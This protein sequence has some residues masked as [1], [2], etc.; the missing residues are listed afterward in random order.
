MDQGTP[1][2]NQEQYPD[3]RNRRRAQDQGRYY[4]NRQR[5]YIQRTRPINDEDYLEEELPVEEYDAY[6][7]WED[8]VNAGEADEETYPE[9]IPRRRRSS[10]YSSTPPRR[11]PGPREPARARPVARKRPR[12]RK[13]SLPSMLLGCGLGMLVAVGLAIAVVLYFV[14]PSLKN[15]G[16]P[17]N[18][19]NPLHQ[20]TKEESVTTPITSLGTVEVCTK[21]GNVALLVD[22]SSATT[23]ITSKKM[24][25]ATSQGDA[26]QK[27]AQ[28]KV[29]IQ[30]PATVTQPLTCTRLPNP[31]NQQGTTASGEALI[32]NVVFPTTGGL[33]QDTTASTDITIH[34]PPGILPQTPSLQIGVEAPVGNITV[35]GLSGVYS[36]HGNTGAIK[37]TQAIL[38]SGSRLETGQKGVTFNGLLLIPPT[39]TATAPARYYI[40]SEQGNV[41][42]TLPA[43]LNIQVN[44]TTNIGKIKSDFPIQ[45]QKDPKDENSMSYNGPLNPQAG[46][47][48]PA[49]L[50]L[51]VSIGN[52]NLHKAP[53]A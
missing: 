48:A 26:Q 2:G 3:G 27:F 20:Y 46:T 40:R 35:Q 47:P 15:G 34:I 9:Y 30:P 10:A 29:E 13:S 31:T 11:S 25:Q 6:D 21:I 44:L 28:M 37:V 49:S 50:N 33:A 43:N 1:R 53:G 41:D 22:P 38:A 32:V 24:V 18:P 7:A 4:T 39:A 52:I 5:P 23:T 45:P 12:R 14:V 51:D 17:V 8:S 19:F 16:T 42:V 36:L